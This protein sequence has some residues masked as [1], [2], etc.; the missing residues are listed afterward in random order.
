[1][2]HRYTT[3]RYKVSFDF[4]LWQADA[5]DMLERGK[6]DLILHPDDGLLPSHLSSQRLYEEWIW[7]VVRESKFSDRL[8]LK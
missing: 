6:L 5:V 3:E 1:L 2:C 8:T 4:L 7:A